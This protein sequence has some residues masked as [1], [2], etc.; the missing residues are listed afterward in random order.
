LEGANLTIT[1]L[2]GDPPLSGLELYKTTTQRTDRLTPLLGH[3]NNRI[4]VDCGS[5]TFRTS[6]MGDVLYP[7]TEAVTA[8]GLSRSPVTVPAV[9]GQPAA[10]DLVDAGAFLTECTSLGGAIVATFGVIA[11]QRYDITLFWMEAM[12]AAATR[13]RK[14]QALSYPQNWACSSG[15]QG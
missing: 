4:V 14:T 12:C 11:G 10:Q 9:A 5:L 15:A 1:A 7:D 8:A 2:N 3:S 13:A 6:P